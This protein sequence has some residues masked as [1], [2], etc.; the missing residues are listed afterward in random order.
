MKEIAVVHRTQNKRESMSYR[1]NL[2]RREKKA[3]CYNCGVG[4]VLSEES[5]SAARKEQG[6]YYK[7]FKDIEISALGLVSLRLPAISENPLDWSIL[8][9]KRQYEILSKH[10]L[11]VW[12]MEPLKGGR[13]ATRVFREDMGVP[14]S[15]CRYCCPVCPAGL[16]I[17]LLIKGYNEVSVSG[18]TWRIAE[19]KETKLRIAIQEQ[20][21]E[22]FDKFSKF[23]YGKSNARYRLYG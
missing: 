21:C 18:D 22:C 2:I 12:V 8:E 6:M 5:R 11:P 4:R 9:A 16:D 3:K 14:C 20:I 15:A 1:H 19:L 10:H 23:I 13:L 7:K 17:P